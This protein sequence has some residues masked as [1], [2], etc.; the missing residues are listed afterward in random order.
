MS[1]SLRLALIQL[2]MRGLIVTAP[3]HGMRLKDIAALE[4]IADDE[5][6][7]IFDW[8]DLQTMDPPPRQL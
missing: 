3:R 1:I 4:A 2:E 7:A 6:N 5:E 8:L